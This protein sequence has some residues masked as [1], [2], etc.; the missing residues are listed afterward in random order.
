MLDAEDADRVSGS[1]G[2]RITVIVQ[3]RHVFDTELVTGR[4]IKETAGVPA[5]FALYRRVRGGNEQ[6][7]DDAQVELRDGD[8]FFA[9]PPSRA[10]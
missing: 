4:Q 1:S 10:P 9:R 6:V 3:N 8:H 5:G 7:A 2:V